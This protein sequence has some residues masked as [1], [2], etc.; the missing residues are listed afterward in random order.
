LERLVIEST[1]RY[2]KKKIHE[3][4]EE[5]RKEGREPKLRPWYNLTGRELDKFISILLL[6]GV[7]QKRTDT[8]SWW[9]KNFYLRFHNVADI[10]PQMRYFF[11]LLYRSILSFFFLSSSS[12]IYLLH[13][14]SYYSF[15]CSFSD[16]KHQVCYTTIFLS[17]FLTY[18]FFHIHLSFLGTIK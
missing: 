9:S 12:Y 11:F 5:I 7:H 10:M 6:S 3:S 16:N 1:N 14:L 18:L 15:L 8:A 4:E 17:F 13:H 2:A